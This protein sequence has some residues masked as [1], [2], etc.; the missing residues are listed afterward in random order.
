MI[1][2]IIFENFYPLVL[3][4]CSL[5]LLNFRNDSKKKK[6]KKQMINCKVKTKVRLKVRISLHFINSFLAK[7]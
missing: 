4:M 7:L 6:Q 1:R 3:K 5:T 2:V